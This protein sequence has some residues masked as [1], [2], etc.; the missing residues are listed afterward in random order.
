VKI[1]STP[2]L[3]R[4]T[5]LA[6]ATFFFF[7]W[8]H[9]H[10]LQTLTKENTFVIMFFI[11]ACF[12]LLVYMDSH[13]I[14]L[15]S[16]FVSYV[17]FGK[18]KILPYHDIQKIEISYFHQ[19]VRTIAPVLHIK[20]AKNE[21]QIPFGLFEKRFFEIHQLIQAKVQLNEKP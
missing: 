18:K 10:Q 7:V 2:L 20:G 9:L 6:F 4:F 19:N 16:D 1:H 3:S 15:A 13:T 11:T 8:F 5:C 17:C 21:I 12:L 14:E